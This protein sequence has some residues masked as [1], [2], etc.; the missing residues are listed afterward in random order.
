MKLLNGLNEISE[1]SESPGSVEDLEKVRLTNHDFMSA[2]TSYELS[3]IGIPWIT[4]SNP[5]MIYFRNG[6]LYWIVFTAPVMVEATDVETAES[7]IYT[8]S[9]VILAFDAT[10]GRTVSL[11]EALGISEAPAVYYGL[12][13]L[14]EGREMVF[15]NT[16]KWREA[17]RVNYSGPPDYVFS[18]W[19]RVAF[20]LLKGRLDIASGGYGE[21]L[22]TLMV[23]DAYQRV[24]KITMPLLKMETDPRTNTPAPYPVVDPEGN[25][26]LLSQYLSRNRFILSTLLLRT[27]VLRTVVALGN[28]S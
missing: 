3:R 19:N 4:Q 15:V 1:V 18:G 14:F 13:G 7:F 11:S 16:G 26:Y 12:G 23:R 20:F 22:N 10:T 5:S 25:L 17:G 8:H 24:S 6:R 28:P 2:R 21:V 9:E 27:I